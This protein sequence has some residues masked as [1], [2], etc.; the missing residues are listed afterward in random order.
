MFHAR[1]FGFAFLVV[2]F[3][4]SATFARADFNSLTLPRAFQ[5]TAPEG[6][7]DLQEIQQHV[8]KLAERVI[9]AT[10]GLRIGGSSGSGVIIDKEGHVL[11]AGHVSGKP[12]QDV[13]IILYD[14][15]KVKGKT[16]GGNRGIDSGMVL[17]TDKGDWNYCEMAK[18]SELKKGHWCMAV[19]HPNGY[20]QG[21]PP[22]VRLG[23]VLEIAK[24]RSG[25]PSLLRTDC[26]LVGGDSGGPLFDMFGNVIGIHS[27]IGQ[28][29]TANIHVPI[30]TYRDTWDR[31]AKG[32]IWG[33]NLFGGKGKGPK[34]TGGDAYLGVTPSPDSKDYKIFRVRPE[35]PADKAG[36]KIDDIIVSIDGKKIATNDDLVGVLRTKQPGNL[37]AV[38]VRRGTDMLNL[39]VTLSKRPD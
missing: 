9:P 3:G 26:A 8:A 16:L 21:R 1:R 27:R 24:D 4:L 5:K 14:G 10:V 38:E 33:D 22:V 7:K 20:W 39:K 12:D 29:M 37:V 11:T 25:N 19:G 34:N 6:V 2:A 13:Q 35:S 15:K 28:P 36:L 32:E 31:L 17:I 30:D 18:I 23:R